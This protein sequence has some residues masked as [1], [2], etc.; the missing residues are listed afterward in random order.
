MDDLAKK[1][2]EVEDAHGEQLVEAHIERHRQMSRERAIF[3][4]GG[5][6]ATGKIAAALDAD[7]IKGLILFQE[8]K[9]HEALGF[10]RFADFLN[11]SEL[12]PMSKRQFYDRKDLLEKEGDVVFDLL[13]DLGVSIRK[14]KLL[15][16]GNVE[17]DANAETVIIRDGDE[18]TA[19]ELRDRTRILET[20]SALA[21]ANADKSAKIE[22]LQE[23]AERHEDK[24]RELYAEID[25]EK[26]RKMAAYASDPHMIA[27]VEMNLALGKMAQTAEKLSDIEKDQFRDVVLEE[28]AAHRNALANAYRVA[29]RAKAAAAAIDGTGMSDGEFIAALLDT[30]DLSG[31]D[32]EADLASQL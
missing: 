22:R 14:R 27:R 12:S 3:V 29:G 23:K 8:Q 25:A 2:R 15:G 28:L 18:K 32:N 30:V 6:R 21:D 20:L 11:D 10:D 24:V 16:K 31:S 5:I 19:I 4:L 1:I 26:A 17:I 9:G 7:A 13:N